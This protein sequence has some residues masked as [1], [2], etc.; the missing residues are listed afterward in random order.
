MNTRLE[1]LL[2]RI[3]PSRTI[4]PFEANLAWALAHPGFQVR[5]IRDEYTLAICLAKFVVGVR[6]GPKRSTLAM[7]GESAGML[8][9]VIFDAQTQQ[10]L[11]QQ[12]GQRWQQVVLEN[13]CHGLEG[14]LRRVLETLG[15]GVVEQMARRVIHEEVSRY[16]NAQ[17]PAE[18]IEAPREYYARFG[19]L[20][21][22]I[23]TSGMDRRLQIEFHKVLIEHPFMLRGLGRVSL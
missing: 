6:S 7:R 2:N 15:A 8:E 21:P 14:G 23:I 12:Y 19:R 13:V 18:R 3:H 17:S 4:D 9:L 22:S 16:L 11:R 1:Q 5:E 10:I 20:L